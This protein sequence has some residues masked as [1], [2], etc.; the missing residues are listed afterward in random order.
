MRQVIQNYRTGALEV[1]EVPD[2]VGRP[3]NL[4]VRTAASVVSTGTE[5]HLVEMAQKSLVGKALSRPDLV[6][7]VWEKVCTDGVFET[8]EQVRRR[9]ETPVALGYSAS[10][11]V[12]AVADG[13]SGFRGGG[14]G[15]AG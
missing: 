13:V 15:A 1:V 9:L 10:G 3:G 14:R 4:L 8:Y 6:R 11:I 12:A 7:R 5:R 2:P